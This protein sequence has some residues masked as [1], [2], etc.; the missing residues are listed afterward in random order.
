MHIMLREV[1]VGSTED[2]VYWVDD[3]ALPLAGGSNETQQLM[4][5]FVKSEQNDLLYRDFEFI[6]K[7]STEMAVTFF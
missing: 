3:N 1:V 7:Q 2:I 4:R 5:R 6:Y